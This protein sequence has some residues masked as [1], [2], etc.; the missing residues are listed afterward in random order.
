MP[1][2][3]RAAKVA[4]MTPGRPLIQDGAVA[5]DGTKILAVGHFCEIKGQWAG[6]VRDLGDVTLAPAALNAHTHLE[7]THLLGRVERGAGFAAW[8]RSLLAQGAYSVDDAQVRRELAL[9]EMRGVGF[10]ADISTKN[11]GRMAALLC[12]SGLFFCSFQEAIGSSLAADPS[13]L[14]HAL[15][16]DCAHPER[17][18]CAPAGHALYTTAPGLLRQAKAAAGAGPFSLHLAEH[19]DEDEIL[20][21]GK[22]PFLD[23]MFERGFMTS[24]DAPGKRPVPLARELGLLDERTLAVHC[25]RLSDEDISL[26][27]ESRAT[28]CLCPRSNAYIGV[29]QPRARDLL[30]AGVPLCL[31]TD[32]LCSNDDLDPLRELVW[33]KERLAP[34]LSLVDGL[35]MLTTTP[36]RFF[37]LSGRLGSLAPGAA[38]RF[39]VLPKAVEAAF[40]DQ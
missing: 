7:M 10:A 39:C 5:H 34:E 9:M 23:L 26:L 16:C 19:Q 2:L 6:P 27:A 12:A 14:A 28:V 20:M 3:L 31:G 18:Q 25:V 8:A 22:G 24:F 1:E 37:G 17:G 35:A 32:G 38:A 15:P 29:G 36:A 4:P 13:A 11:A 33:V 40:A 30:R 21:T